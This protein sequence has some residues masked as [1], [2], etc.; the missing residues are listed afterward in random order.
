MRYR[1]F[2][3]RSGLKISEIALGARGA[4]LGKS[5]LTQLGACLRSLPAAS[6]LL[7]PSRGERWSESRGTESHAR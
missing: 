1:I 4:D 2:G 3:Q 5:G 7:G 6:Q